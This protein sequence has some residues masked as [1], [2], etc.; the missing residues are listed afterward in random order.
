MGKLEQKVCLD[1]D[2]V[3]SILNNESRSISLINAIE[4]CEV[5]I[6]T[7]NL[8]ELLL[9]KTNLEEIEIFRKKTQLL[10]FEENASREASSVFK[11]LKKKGKL[12]E[13]R[14]I[15]IASICIANNCTLA[16]F[17]KKHFENIKSLNLLEI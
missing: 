14:D 9:R 7:I 10:D 15:F 1:T 5:H 8:F 13:F 6:T 17:N 16:T 11:E 4:D 12:I 3:I 2:A